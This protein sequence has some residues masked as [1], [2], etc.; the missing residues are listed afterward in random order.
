MRIRDLGDDVFVGCTTPGVLSHIAPYKFVCCHLTRGGYLADPPMRLAIFIFLSW[1]DSSLRV[2][3]GGRNE[4]QCQPLHDSAS[5]H[6]DDSAFNIGSHASTISRALSPA[7]IM[8]S[9]L[10]SM[11]FEKQP[12]PVD[13]ST[14]GLGRTGGNTIHCLK[15]RVQIPKR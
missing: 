11:Y 7:H 4:L 9:P 2:K 8:A 12:M 13:C 3:A 15:R 10:P 14:L 1:Q 6:S 5:V